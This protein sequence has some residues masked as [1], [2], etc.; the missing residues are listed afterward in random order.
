MLVSPALPFL[1]FALLAASSNVV[2][3][4]TTGPDGGRIADL[5]FQAAKS[6]LA[7][8]N[9]SRQPRPPAWASTGKLAEAIAAT[10]RTHS[11]AMVFDSTVNKKRRVLSITVVSED[12]TLVYQGSTKL[13]KKGFEPAVRSLAAEAVAAANRKLA[14]SA[15]PSEARVEAAP[16][17]N[18]EHDV[19]PDTAE[20]VATSEPEATPAPDELAATAWTTTPAAATQ[21]AISPTAAR[22][23]PLSISAQLGGGVLSYQDTVQSNS[24]LGE[25][26]I[27]TPLGNLLTLAVAMHAEAGWWVRT[28]LHT[29][30]AALA[31]ASVQPELRIDTTLVGGA[32][33]GGYR[34]WLGGIAVGGAVGAGFDSFTSSAQPTALLV[35]GWTRMTALFGAT[36]DVGQLSRDG[37]EAGLALLAVPWGTQRERPATSGTSAQVL[38]G[39]GELRARY[40]I[41]MGSSW[42]PYV[43]LGGTFELLKISYSGTGTR[44]L[45]DGVTLAQDASETRRTINGYLAAG[46]SF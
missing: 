27:N 32:L 7:G 11:V 46:A 5:L 31:S 15:P 42:A 40:R 34:R 10:A 37:W 33:T 36:F 23:H 41:P 20:P 39:R 16:A 2:V 14:P 17:G 8:Y 38:G 24:G 44:V 4:E 43:E 30:T 18:T 9:V 3:V 19:P 12:G 35:P 45:L 29:G 1:S 13:R 26:N 21:R 25:L 6:E 22:A 28:T